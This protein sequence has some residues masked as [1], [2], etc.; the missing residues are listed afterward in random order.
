[1]A[2]TPFEEWVDGVGCVEEA[3]GRPGTILELNRKHRSSRH[4]LRLLSKK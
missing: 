2:R 4:V 3:F 1:M